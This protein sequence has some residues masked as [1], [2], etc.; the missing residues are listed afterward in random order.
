MNPGFIKLM[1]LTDSNSGGGWDPNGSDKVFGIVD[2]K[3]DIDSVVLINMF[4]PTTT[5]HF[6][7]PQPICQVYALFNE[8]GFFFRCSSAPEERSLLNYIVFRPVPS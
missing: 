4:K 6:T 7:V 2:D 8:G 3:V 1:K 5:F